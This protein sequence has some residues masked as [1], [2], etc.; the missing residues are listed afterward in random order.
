[1]V[2]HMSNL[3]FCSVV[4]EFVEEGEVVISQ[5]GEYHSHNTHRLDETELTNVLLNLREIQDD[6]KGFETSV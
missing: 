5:A 2:Q 3:F 6:L 4:D 1:M